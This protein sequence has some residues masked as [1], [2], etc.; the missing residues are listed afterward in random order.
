MSAGK[1]IIIAAI[2]GGSYYLWKQSQEPT[3]EVGTPMFQPDP[4]EPQPIDTH[5]VFT[6][7]IDFERMP[8]RYTPPRTIEPVRPPPAVVAVTR[9]EHSDGSVTG[10]FR[11][12]P[13][14]PPPPQPEPVIPHMPVYGGRFS[15]GPNKPHLI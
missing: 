12:V 4:G 7:P 2:A 8:P 10:S 6:T 15:H 14:T 13:I 9:V 1:I 5:P 3:P 11:P